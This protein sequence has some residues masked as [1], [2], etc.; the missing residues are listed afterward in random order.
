MFKIHHMIKGIAVT[1]LV[2]LGFIMI[3]WAHG[4]SAPQPARGETGSVKAVQ[5]RITL[6]G[7]HWANVTQVE[8]TAF[9]VERD[10]KKLT[11]TPYIRDGG[12]VELRIFKA[13]QN[14][15]KETM[16]AVGVLLAGK[17]LTKLGAGLVL[18]VQVLNANKSLSSDLLAA[19]GFTCCAR[20]CNGTLVCGAV[21]VCTDCSRCGP[22]WC[23]CAIPGPRRIVK[24]SATG[25]GQAH[26][27][28]LAS[29]L[30]SFAPAAVAARNESKPKISVGHVRGKLQKGFVSKVRL[31][32]GSGQ[33]RER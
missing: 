1:L 9:T 3:V 23:D 33:Y 29:R 7:G 12:K 32:L 28:G 26:E 17:G 2:A 31:A 21:C 16:E 30:T 20:A 24:R 15:G 11:L 4:R 13:V 22:N 14:G 10:G 27:G 8:G 6:E 19:S 5:L 25:G 18:G